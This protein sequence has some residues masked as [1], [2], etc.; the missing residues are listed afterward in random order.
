[1]GEDIQGKGEEITRWEKIHCY[2]STSFVLWKDHIC[3]FDSCS[4]NQ[5]TLHLCLNKIYIT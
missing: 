5:F 1:M 2:S 4:H 3:S